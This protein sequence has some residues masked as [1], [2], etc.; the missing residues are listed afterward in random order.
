MITDDATVKKR[1][2]MLWELHTILIKS[3]Q[4]ILKDKK[5]P[6]KASMISCIVHFLRDNGISVAN[7]SAGSLDDAL[8]SMEDLEL[9]FPS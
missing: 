2:E 3:F 9:P 8:R 5:N 4:D 7:K 1:R 6:P